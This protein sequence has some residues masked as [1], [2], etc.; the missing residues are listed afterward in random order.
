M[1]IVEKIST[2]TYIDRDIETD[3]DIQMA[4]DNLSEEYKTVV[5]LRYFEDMKISDIAKILDKNGLE[6]YVDVAKVEESKT[7]EK[8]N[9][10]GHQMVRS[11]YEVKANNDDFKTIKENQGFYINGKNELVIC[12]DKYEVGPGSIGGVDFTIPN[13]VLKPNLN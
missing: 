13:E 4:L 8:N 5:I 1:Q 3:I 10:Q 7:L 9:K 11:S 6:V 12:F 2:D